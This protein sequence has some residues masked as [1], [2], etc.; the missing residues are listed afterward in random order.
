[1]RIV[2]LLAALALLTISCGSAP[3]PAA[4]ELAKSVEPPKPADESQRFPT[5]NL[6]KTEV[7]DKALLGKQF[8]PGGTVAH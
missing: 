6:V 2:A 7:V 4:Q 8:M 3:K 1:M 5:A